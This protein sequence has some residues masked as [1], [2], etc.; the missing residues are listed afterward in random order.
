MQERP[1]D[2]VMTT[3]EAAAY[4]KLSPRTLV[5]LRAR[6]E[7]PPGVRIGRQWRYR[8]SSLDSWLA[9]REITGN[10]PDD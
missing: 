2:E 4:L 8:R 5:S 9:E 3:E 10:A 1:P 7:A 6:G